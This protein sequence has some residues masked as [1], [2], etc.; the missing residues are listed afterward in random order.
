MTLAVRA[1]RR[2]HTVEGFTRL[3]LF[4]AEINEFAH[5]VNGITI[6]INIVTLGGVSMAMA[7]SPVAVA[8]SLVMT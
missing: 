5:S 1:M 2:T 6:V 8:M 4:T 7:L 3:G